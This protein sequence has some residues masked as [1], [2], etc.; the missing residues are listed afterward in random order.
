[1]EVR[2]EKF[3]TFLKERGIACI[4]FDM[5]H[6]MSAHHCGPG[7]LKI[8]LKEYIGAASK[9]FVS[10]ATSL[11]LYN[12]QKGEEHHFFLAVATGSD[13]AEYELEGQ[14]RDTHILGPDLATA[15]IRATCPASVLPLFKIMVGFDYRLHGKVPNQKGKRK[16]MRDI[17]KFYGIPMSKMLIIDDSES[18]LE[19]EEGYHGLLV[20]NR[21]VGFTYE[22]AEFYMQDSVDSTK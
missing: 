14:S 8:K 1:M 20:R 13:P 11:A 17:S 6:T 22:D 3:I 12:S 15:L 4:V 19:N 10:L 5:D 9:D 16:H 18:S 2:A 21:D 7:L